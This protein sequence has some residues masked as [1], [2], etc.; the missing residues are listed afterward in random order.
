MNMEFQTGRIPRCESIAERER[1]SKRPLA[2]GRNSNSSFRMTNDSILTVSVSDQERVAIDVLL[3]YVGIVAA[4]V[5]TAEILTILILK[6]A[7]VFFQ[8]R[9][10]SVSFLLAD[11]LFQCLSFANALLIMYWND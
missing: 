7:K 10:F 3:A 6:R 5:A 11:T 2:G 8:I 4:L 1:C 9:Y